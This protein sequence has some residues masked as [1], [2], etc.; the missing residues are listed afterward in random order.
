MIA[1][2]E[3]LVGIEPTGH[4]WFDL[5]QFMGEKNIKFV[6]VNPHHVHKT[7]ELDDNSPSKNDRKDPRVIAGLVRDGRYF[8]SYMPTGVYAELRNAS[9]RRFV[10]V[11]EQTRAKNRLQKW[12]AVYFQEYKGVYTHIDAKG[13]LLVLKEAPTPEEI[14]KL[15]EKDII[16]IW[17][18]AK[19]RGNGHKKGNEYP[20]CGNEKHRIKSR[21]YRSMDGDTG[22]DRGL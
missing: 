22:S 5:G 17:K 13:G 15:G 20:E 12:I 8:Y 6:M 9:N 16:K 19:L 4:Y 2:Q 10:L 18:D 11:E 21:P 1:V 7:K 3:V 14:V